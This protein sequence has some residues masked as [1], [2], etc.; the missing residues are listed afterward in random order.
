MP[1]GNGSQSIRCAK[2]R[3]PNFEL[4]V[5]RSNGLHELHPRT[6]PEAR[7]LC[8]NR[9]KVYAKLLECR[10]DGIQGLI[11]RGE[12]VYG[13]VDGTIPHQHLQPCKSARS[14]RDKERIKVSR[15]FL[16]NPCENL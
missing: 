15:P 10:M 12:V 1:T 6:L 2:A 5:R 13:T 8:A 16:S 7:A 4:Y 11:Q 9:P 14:A 3:Q